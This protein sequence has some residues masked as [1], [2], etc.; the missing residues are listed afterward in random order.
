ME[1]TIKPPPAK[2][3]KDKWY[4]QT[5]SQIPRTHLQIA[6]SLLWWTGA[7]TAFTLR[8]VT[9]G[10]V[11]TIFSVI[12][13]V[14]NKKVRTSEIDKDIN[15][16]TSYTFVDGYNSTMFVSFYYNY[17]DQLIAKYENIYSN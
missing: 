17:D 11:S 1:G 7:T 15:F 5:E 13:V 2:W 10:G 4:L 3:D 14:C 16:C 9:T 12:T 6:H 8:L